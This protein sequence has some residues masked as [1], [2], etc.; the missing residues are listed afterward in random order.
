MDARLRQARPLGR[1]LVGQGLACGVEAV[2]HFRDWGERMDMNIREFDRVAREV[3]AP[4]YPVIAGQIRARTGITA[5]VCLDIGTGGGYLGIALAGLTD[6]EF[7]LMDKSP[8]MLEIA[9]MNVVGAGLQ[10][11]VR[12]ILGDVHDIPREDNSV[13]LVISRGSL[14]FWEDKSRAFS[15]I[16]RVLKPGGKAYVGGGMGTGKLYRKI[17]EEMEKRNPERQEDGKEGRFADHREL[18]REALNRAGISTYTLIRGDE[19]SWIQIAK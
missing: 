19:G 9:Y 14:F 12:T 2:C 11:R 6:L 7:Y 3:F 13:D 1:P 8:E 16:H 10:N 15:E 17:R 5:G 4:V 18:Y